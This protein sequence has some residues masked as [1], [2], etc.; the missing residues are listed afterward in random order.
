MRTRLISL[1]AGFS[2]CL[3]AAPTVWA[4]A[5]LPIYTDNLVN[6]FQDWS[7]A[8]RDFAN[9]TPTHT[10]SRSIRVTTTAGTGISFYHSDFNTSPYTNFSFWAHGGTNGGQRL[11]VYVEYG[12]GSSGPTYSLPTTLTTGTWTQ[13]VIP[14]TTLGVANRADVHRINILLTGTGTTT[15][16]YL[17]DIQIGARVAPALVQLSVNVTNTLRGADSRWL[18]LNTA[19]WDGNFDTAST[20]NSLRELGTRLLRFPGGSLSDE[21]HWGTGKTL[22]NTWAW[23]TSF[24]NFMHLA[25]NGGL[26]A[27]ITVN[28]GTG[29]SNEAAGW[30]RSAN[31]TNKCGFKYWEI[32]NECYG[33]WETDS[34]SP[35]HDPYTYAVR[36]AGYI[37]L[38]KAADSNI[39]IG[40]VTTPGEDSSINNSNH[41]AFNPRTGQTHYGWTPVVLSTL[42]NLGVTPDFLVH[43]VYPQWT[44]TGSPPPVGNS[45]PLLL[46][47]AVNW[48]IDAAD[49][50]QQ[51]TDYLGSSG[52]NTEILCTENNSEAGAQGRQS[53]SIV[54]ALYL[55]D[56]LSQ[57]MKTEI[58]AYVW[59]DLRNGTDTNGTANAGTFDATLYGWRNY[60]DIGMIRDLNTRYPTFYAEKLM[61]YFVQPGDTVLGANSDYLLLSAYAA[62]KA[63]GALAVLVINK[64]VTTNFSGQVTLS[65]FTPGPTATTRSFGIQQDE[66]TRTNNP[67]PGSQDIAT[68]SVAASASFTSSFPA[69]S[70]TLFTFAPDAPRVL[71]ASMPA[72]GQF[73]FQL[74][75]Q[76]GT[77]CVV[78]SSPDLIGW[79]AISTNQ[80]PGLT[81]NSTLVITNSAGVDQKFWRAL[82][83]P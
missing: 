66:N 17:D 40:V 3:A 22:S 76:G 7:W 8:T 42:K 83:Q 6:G 79:T 28:Y 10:G 58:D 34:N 31:I 38:M 13:Y 37:A 16:F 32:G 43:H 39:L 82:W 59:W 2:I 62:R 14:L 23:A 36:A 81:N 5:N 55:A 63:N 46:Q 65:N 61:Q 35:A 29:T 51:I 64:D 27:M 80:L 21:Y 73:V 4:Q 20:S 18:A 53:T 68:N 77:P 48:A 12:S 9:T 47:A 70:L 15:T 75:G 52:T 25:T 50:R 69:G 74:Q 67:T 44:A 54:N 30:V 72:A 26:Q 1:L 56:S 24:G 19:V 49:L 41:S 11:Q 45:D 60:G 71:N 57:L 78:Q 33:T